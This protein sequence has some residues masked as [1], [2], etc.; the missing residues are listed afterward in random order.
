MILVRKRN[1][2]MVAQFIYH[3]FSV[4]HAWWKLYI[5]AKMF[6]FLYATI[7][8]PLAEIVPGKSVYVKKLTS[9]VS[10]RLIHISNRIFITVSWFQELRVLIIV[11]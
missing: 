5:W 3:E 7:V 2:E 1:S 6:V 8:E 4:E 10:I 9:F 11:R